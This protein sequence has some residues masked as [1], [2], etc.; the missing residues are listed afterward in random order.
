LEP[1]PPVAL[2]SAPSHSRAGR[3]RSHPVT[4]RLPRTC[5]SRST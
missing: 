4:A 3:P 1:P 5:R 2:L